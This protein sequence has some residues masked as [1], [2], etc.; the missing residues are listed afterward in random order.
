VAFSFY[1]SFKHE[2][3]NCRLFLW[4]HFVRHSIPH[5]KEQL[6]KC[7]QV[8]VKYLLICLMLTKIKVSISCNKNSEYKF[9]Q[10]H[11]VVLVHHYQSNPYKHKSRTLYVHLLLFCYDMFLSYHWTIIKRRIPVYIWK[12]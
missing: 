10:H 12:S 6:H 3:L 8:C 9:G 1:V 4:P 11:P 7:T 2:F 5:Y